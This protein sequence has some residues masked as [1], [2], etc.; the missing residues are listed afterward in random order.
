MNKKKMGY[1]YTLK[2]YSAIKWEVSQALVVHTSNPCYY[3]GRDQEDCGSRP[4]QAKSLQEPSQPV[5]R[6]GGS[7]LLTQ[8]LW[9]A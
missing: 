3:R 4:A 6:Y 7:H 2:Y 8:I 5:A 1:T 9:E